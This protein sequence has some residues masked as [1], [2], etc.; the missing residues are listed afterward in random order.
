MDIEMI[1]TG[2]F[3]GAV[4]ALSG[5]FK[6]RMNAGEPV[7]WVKAG[8]TMATG[9]IVGLFMS[10]SNIE[11]IEENFCAQMGLFGLLTVIIEDIFKGAT[12][13][14]VHPITEGATFSATR[15]ETILTGVDGWNVR[16][17]PSIWVRHLPDEKVYQ[18]ISPTGKRYSG[19]KDAIIYLVTSL[20]ADASA[21]RSRKR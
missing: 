18:A 5:Y 16:L 6:T 8:A 11:F 13:E 15:G 10:Y 1:I 7:S 4:L 2:A 20:N 19:D 3:V 17:N 21:W 14:R 12:R 9:A